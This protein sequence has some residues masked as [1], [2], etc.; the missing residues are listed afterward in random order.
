ME[1]CEGSEGE[2]Y[3]VERMGSSAS[4]AYWRLLVLR[5][6]TSVG[7]SQFASPAGSAKCLTRAAV[8][9]RWIWHGPLD[10]NFLWGEA[11]SLIPYALL[12]WRAFAVALQ[13]SDGD[14]RLDSMIHTTTKGQG[15]T[16][17]SMAS[18]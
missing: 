9:C 2:G 17:P 11:R 10:R 1:A 12:S 8:L 16:Q 15:G 7:Y 4:L 14:D 5:L 6:R 3:R 18:A 13:A